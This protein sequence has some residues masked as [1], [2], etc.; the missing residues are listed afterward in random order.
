MI[1][2]IMAEQIRRKLEVVLCVPESAF[3]FDKK[4]LFLHYFIENVIIY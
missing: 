4:T 2:F 1:N 3:Y